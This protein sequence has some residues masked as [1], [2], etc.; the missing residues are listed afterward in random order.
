MHANGTQTQAIA[1]NRIQDHATNMKCERQQRASEKWQRIMP[2]KSVH[3]LVF[4]LH[5]LHSRTTRGQNAHSFRKWKKRTLVEHT[6]NYNYR[7]E[8]L[9]SGSVARIQVNWIN[10]ENGFDN[11]QIREAGEE[12]DHTDCMPF[13]HQLYAYR[14]FSSGLEYSLSIAPDTPDNRK[15]AQKKGTPNTRAEWGKYRERKRERETSEM[16]TTSVTGN[17]P[18]QVTHKHRHTIRY[19]CER[20]LLW[21]V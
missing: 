11:D 15:V 9:L 17:L 16:M 19:A 1:P 14:N 3:L 18:D 10:D 13:I 21:E 20:C 5:Y 12:P 4:R 2:A 7:Q 8:S 6:D